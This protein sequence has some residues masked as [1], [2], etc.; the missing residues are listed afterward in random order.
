VPLSYFIEKPFQNWTRDTADILGTV[1][2]YLDYT[3]PLDP[4]RKEFKRLLESNPLWDKRVSVMQIT[5]ATERTI[6]E[7][8]LMSASSSGNAFDLRCDIREGLLRFLQQHYPHCF[9][10]T[11]AL[12]EKED[13]PIQRYPKKEGD[14]HPSGPSLPDSHPSEKGERVGEPGLTK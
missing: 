6:E 12:I 7:R 2:L 13:R 8:A 10:V 5:N 3:I 14:S 9:P 4:L 11:R 1:F